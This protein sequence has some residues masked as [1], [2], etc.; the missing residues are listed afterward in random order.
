MP[1]CHLTLTFVHLMK[2][3][4]HRYTMNRVLLLWL[5]PILHKNIK[6]GCKSLPCTNTLAY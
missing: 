2:P 6:Q 4:T 3:D 1:S 5:I